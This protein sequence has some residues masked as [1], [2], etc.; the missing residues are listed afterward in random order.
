MTPLL[1][2][3]LAALAVGPS[4]VAA[5]LARS[6]PAPSDGPVRRVVLLLQD[7]EDQIKKEMKTDQDTYD[8]LKCWCKHN[9]QQESEKKLADMKAEVQTL[10]GRVITLTQAAAQY[11]IDIAKISNDIQDIN[12]AIT[13]ATTVR[14]T[15][16]QTFL[17]NK[18]SENE[19][20]VGLRKVLDVF[21]KLRNGGYN[22]SN[23]TTTRAPGGGGAGP[24]PP[25]LLLQH[26][27]EFI[28]MPPGLARR[29][30]EVMQGNLGRLDG[31]LTTHQ[32]T[33]A[34]SYLQTLASGGAVDFP[35]M[36][37]LYGTLSAMQDG[38]ETTMYKEQLA[39]NRSLNSFN[40]LVASKQQEASLSQTQKEQKT[41]AKV[42]AE[43]SLAAAHQDIADLNA[44]ILSDTTLLGEAKVKCAAAD[45]DWKS[46]TTARTDELQAITQAIA[47]LSRDEARDIFARSV[48]TTPPPAFLEF[49]DKGILPVEARHVY[50]KPSWMGPLSLFQNSGSRALPASAPS[51]LQVSSQSNQRLASGAAAAAGSA[52]ASMPWGLQLISEATGNALR[53]G[54]STMTGQIPF[55]MQ[56]VYTAIDK[57]VAQLQK[58]KAADVEQQTYCNTTLLAKQAEFT[59]E[60]KAKSDAEANEDT[61]ADQLRDL[62]EEV[63][64][65]DVNMAALSEEENSAAE[66]RKDEALAFERTVADQMMTQGLLKEAL[67]VL[68]NTYAPKSFVQEQA[69]IQ[70][71]ARVTKDDPPTMSNYTRKTSGFAVVKGLLDGIINTSKAVVASSNLTEQ[72]AIAGYQAFQ[73]SAAT[74]T[75][76]LK[77]E[78]VDKTSEKAEKRVQLMQAN[79]ALHDIKNSV[80]QISRTLDQ[81]HKECDFI[82]NNVKD[83]AAAMNQEIEALGQA[84]LIFQV[85]DNAP[86][87]TAPNQTTTAAN[88]TTS[89]TASAA[90]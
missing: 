35:G 30:L 7:M 22:V 81:I 65:I 70:M 45:A 69:F 84:K 11:G 50:H 5:R 36:D 61:L 3:V 27:A 57:M 20:L 21:V 13:S 59:T 80:Q 15:A 49:H 1:L 76:N 6:N 16:H 12:L 60:M 52:A 8:N 23:L 73:D 58:D 75:A 47:V 86:L 42:E 87:P 2:A 71:A 31:V 17:T 67:V 40:D 4:S 62:G 46:R 72:Q 77:K 41:A 33:G 18:A 32:R 79:E 39:E 83:R 43:S 68:Q 63:E 64:Q 74:L 88:T 78:M 26:D 25:R 90:R 53:G 51:F 56:Q 37:T 14:N 48:A 34:M 66:R 19:T 85:Q 82:L 38:L 55:A 9:A 89:T 24:A 28:Q 29:I 44:T 54:M 10:E